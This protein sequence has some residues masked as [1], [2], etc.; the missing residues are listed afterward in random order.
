MM[1][2]PS[3][4]RR[5]AELKRWSSMSVLLLGVMAAWLFSRSIGH[6]PS[7]QLIAKAYSERRTIDLRIA[8][9]AHSSFH[10][11]RGSDSPRF[12]R[13]QSLLDAEAAIALDL[14]RNPS[15]AALLA[16]RG[17]ANLL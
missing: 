10:V 1:S 5:K 12:A 4:R 9:G 11:Q 6:A 16:A 8:P 7:S 13:P 17:Q 14:R 2:D 3:L 15:D